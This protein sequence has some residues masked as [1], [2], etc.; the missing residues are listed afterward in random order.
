M[1]KPETELEC[2]VA[3]IV[4]RYPAGRE[5]LIPVLQDVQ[6]KFGYLSEESMRELSRQTGISENETY[7]VAT[8]Y[9]QFRFTPPGEHTMRA[10]LGTACHVRGGHQILLELQQRLGIKAGETTVDGKFDL[11]RV[12]C[13]GCCALAPVVV[14]DDRVHARMTPQ[15]ARLLLSRYRDEKDTGN[16]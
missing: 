10:C 15:K 12:A 16:S 8:F 7:G 1:S 3:E 4:A 13:M 2:A 5:S 9:T 14:V 6:G 11:E